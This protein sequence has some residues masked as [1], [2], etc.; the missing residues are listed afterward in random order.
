MFDTHVV[1]IGIE[2]LTCCLGKN[3]TKIGTVVSEQWGN[4]FQFDIGLV[5]IVYIVENVIQYR[6]SCGTTL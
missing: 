2:G 6:F 1:D 4:G 3:L 5:I